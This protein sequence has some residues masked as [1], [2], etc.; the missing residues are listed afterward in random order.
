LK[1]YCFNSI[2]TKKY[3]NFGIELNVLKMQTSSFAILFVLAIVN[4]SGQN[5]LTGVY[6]GKFNG[7]NITL[8]LELTG[9]KDVSGKM[10]DSA[11]SY[12]LTGIYQE[13][14]LKGVITEKKLGLTFEIDAELKDNELMATL[15]LDVFGTIEKMEIQ[16]FRVGYK[17]P[18]NQIKNPVSGKSRDNQVS[19]VWVKESNYSSGY[20]SNGSYGSMSSSESMVFLSDGRMS[21]GGSQTVIGGNNYTGES[22]RQ[23]GNIIP[24]LFWYT[25]NNKIFLFITENNQTQTV[26]LG[27][28]YIENNH[29]LITAGNGEKLL[30][31]KK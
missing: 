3:P 2:Y 4:L 6:E 1:I 21:D 12:D 26:E 27:K 22:T 15:S 30:L 19:G 31:T 24:G 28:Y 8:T 18:D 17:K 9:K 7:D 14:T 25:E 11:N 13:N 23:A 16:L 29:M 10:K 20:G 5:T